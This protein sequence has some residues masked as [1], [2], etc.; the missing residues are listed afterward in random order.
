MRSRVVEL[1]RLAPEL[2][3]TFTTPATDAAQH[4]SRSVPI[5]FA[6]VSD[7]IRTGFGRASLGRAISCAASASVS[8]CATGPPVGLVVWASL[9]FRFDSRL[10]MGL[11]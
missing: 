3:V 10:G 1:I 2:V 8:S 5:I 6:A 7:P 4:A 11:D 9:R